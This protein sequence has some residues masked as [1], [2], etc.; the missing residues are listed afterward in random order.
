MAK[1]THLL[2]S[3][4]FVAF[5]AM[6]KSA[7]KTVGAT[8][9]ADVLTI[10]GYPLDVFQ[11]DDQK[12]LSNMLGSAVVD[13]RPDRDRL[14][15]EPTLLTTAI[16]PLY[17]AVKAAR[18]GK[19]A[20][21]LD[22][23][24][25][26]VESLTNFLEECEFDEDAKAWGIPL[27]GFVPFLPLDPESTAQ[28]TFTVKRLRKAT[29]NMRII[30]IENRHGGRIDRIVP[31]SLAEESFRELQASAKGLEQFYMPAMAQE[32]WSPFEG[33]GM[34][35]LKILALDAEE[36]SKKLRRSIAEVKIARSHV[37]KFWREMHA[38]F[39]T[40]IDLPQGGK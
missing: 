30:L 31:G 27:L 2:I 35:F 15:D 3:T 7:G 36:G 10:N 29:P 18:G 8:F 21:L 26:E 12:R 4:S 23:G 9:T 20:I 39:A 28:A 1:K 19:R 22:T 11:I 16:S 5:F 24:A 17:D 33:A 38:Q 40:I 25:N 32:Y 6:Q 37:A 14:I 34:R 13:L